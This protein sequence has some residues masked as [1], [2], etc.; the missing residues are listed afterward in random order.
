MKFV[1][2]LETW[3]KLTLFCSI[4]NIAAVGHVEEICIAK[5]YQG[6]GLGLKMINAL[7]SI[8]RNVG[9]RKN[10]LNCSP[11]KESFYKKCGYTQSSM[12]MKHQFIDGE[13]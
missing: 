13:E 4:W 7:D 5:D 11:Q 10:I 8:A 1:P 12:E 2:F 9:C 3:S 6:K